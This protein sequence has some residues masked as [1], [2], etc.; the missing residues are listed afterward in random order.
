M[1]I[2]NSTFKFF[3][4]RFVDV[5][6]SANHGRKD[7]IGNKIDI[8]SFSISSIVEILSNRLH[9]IFLEVDLT[10]A[11]SSVIDLTFRKLSVHN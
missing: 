11:V 8:K 1:T 10:C 7:P 6:Q 9:Y 5:K 3:E 2:T 4:A